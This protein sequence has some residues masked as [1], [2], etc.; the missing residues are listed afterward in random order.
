MRHV[1]HENEAKSFNILNFSSSDHPLSSHQPVANP[2]QNNWRT[3]GYY[4]LNVKKKFYKETF[5][6]IRLHVMLGPGI[7]VVT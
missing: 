1:E 5:N 4:Q 7:D 3:L 6:L 2:S